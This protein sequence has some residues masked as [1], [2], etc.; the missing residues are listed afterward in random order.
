MVKKD[1]FGKKRQKVAL[2]KGK[3]SEKKTKIG[4]IKMLKIR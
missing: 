1:K 4:K 2:K 3:K